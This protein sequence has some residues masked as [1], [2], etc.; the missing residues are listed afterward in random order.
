[1]DMEFVSAQQAIFTLNDKIKNLVATEEMR[2]LERFT[3]HILKNKS[4]QA[5]IIRVAYLMDFVHGTTDMLIK[6]YM[7]RFF[8]QLIYEQELFI[9]HKFQRLIFQSRHILNQLEYEVTTYITNMESGGIL[10][11]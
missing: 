2:N 1:M 8:R 9:V 7:Y 10:P 5:N 6:H 3:Q 11:G 4:D